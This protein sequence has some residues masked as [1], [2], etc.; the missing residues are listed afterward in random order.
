MEPGQILP[1]GSRPEPLDTA[2]VDEVQELVWALVDEQISAAQIARLE[3][4]VADEPRARTAYIRCMATHAELQTHFAT[5]GLA[6]ASDPPPPLIP[7]LV[8]D[9]LAGSELHPPVS[10]S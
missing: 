8:M 1:A 5:F 9:G 4:L 2:L 7:R 10:G 6:A 3:R